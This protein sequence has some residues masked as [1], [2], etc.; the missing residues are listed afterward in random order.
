MAVIESYSCE[1]IDVVVFLT[2]VPIA[3]GIG[4][5]IFSEGQLSY[6]HPPKFKRKRENRLPFSFLLSDACPDVKL[7]Q[8]KREEHC[9]RKES[10][11]ATVY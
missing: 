7:G 9:T 2:V 6:P 11:E 10:R 4:R 1:L 8:T 3:I 5:G